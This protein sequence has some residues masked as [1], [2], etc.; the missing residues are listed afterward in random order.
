[1][2]KHQL[3]YS[4][5]LQGA[6]SPKCHIFIKFNHFLIF[7][8]GDIDIIFLFIK[9]VGSCTFHGRL[10]MENDCLQT[11][12]HLLTG[13]SFHGQLSMKLK[14]IESFLMSFRF[15]YNENKVA[16]MVN[17]SKRPFFNIFIKN[18]L[19][20]AK[21]TYTHKFKKKSVITIVN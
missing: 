14:Q 1:M 17:R 20:T 10:S 15:F 4:K 2:R 3:D 13:F 21:I 18:S 11:I 7:S 16:K 8:M 19:F 9:I 12:V 5:F 6:F